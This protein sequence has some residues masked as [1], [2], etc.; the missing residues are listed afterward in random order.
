[1]IDQRLISK[2]VEECH[3]APEESVSHKKSE[4]GRVL[5]QTD[6][7]FRTCSLASRRVQFVER[8]A[9]KPFV[10]SNIRSRMWLSPLLGQRQVLH[11][12]LNDRSC[13]AR[14]PAIL[15]DSRAR[16]CRGD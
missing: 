10:A 12:V 14:A 16:N 6:L 2:F 15:V 9:S 1:M 3:P 5:W 13:G 7:V 8:V 4:E 11:I